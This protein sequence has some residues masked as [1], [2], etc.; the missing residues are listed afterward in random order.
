MAR[1]RQAVVTAAAGQPHAPSRKYC[2]PPL[3][4]G[5]TGER[6]GEASVGDLLRAGAS[7]DWEGCVYRREKV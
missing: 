7:E 2:V 3:V 5:R 4:H 6:G 1:H